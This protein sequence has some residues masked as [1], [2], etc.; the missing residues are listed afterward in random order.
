M[1]LQRDWD[2]FR[3][4]FPELAEKVKSLGASIYEMGVEKGRSSQEF[5]ELCSTL[6]TAPAEALKLLGCTVP[7][8]ELMVL[9]SVITL[10]AQTLY[11]L[12]EGRAC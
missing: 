10:G 3:E 7:F 1:I 11:N 2:Q 5:Q 4:Q 9:R 8:E 12:E 6:A